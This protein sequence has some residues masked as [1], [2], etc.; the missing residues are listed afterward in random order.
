VGLSAMTLPHEIPLS[1]ECYEFIASVVYEHSRIRL[2]KDKQ[3]LLTGRLSKRL[4]ELRLSSYE[5]YCELLRS[6]KGQAELSPLVDLISTNHTHFFR[7]SSHLDFLRDHILPEFIAKNRSGEAFRV[8][9]AAC[10]SGEEPYTV[11]IVLAEYFLRHSERAWEIE[12]TDI[13]TRILAQAK[14]GIYRKDRVSLPDTALLHRY[15]QRGLG[16]YEDYYRV[17][18]SLRAKVKFKHANLLHSPYP[19]AASQHVIF[20]RN[21]MIYFDH[22]TQQELVEKLIAQLAPGGYLIVGH[23]ESLLSVK[24]GLKPMCPAVYHLG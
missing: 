2:G 5:E 11:A 8:W 18:D 9:S 12:A 22:K 24:H 1:P 3:T 14:Q 16:E 13:S 21:V 23:S 10:S 19:V 20:C 6:P 4:R 7:E 17:K 15:F